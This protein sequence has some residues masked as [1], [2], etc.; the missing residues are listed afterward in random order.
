MNEQQRRRVDDIKG[1]L[2]LV[3]FPPPFI[4]DN[5]AVCLLA[6]LD[7]KPGRGDLL[8]GKQTLHDGAR[9]R[10]I[11]DFSRLDLNRPVAENTREEYRKR[12]LKPLVVTGMVAVHASSVNDPNTYYVLNPD[13]EAI[14]R[15]SDSPR[16]RA[17]IEAWNR[18][19]G[20]ILEK[21]KERQRIGQVLVRIDDR[22]IQLS[23]GE[24]NELIV[25]VLE[26]FA[27]ALA[28]G[29][30][31][32]Y[33][34]DQRKKMLYVNTDL[35]ARLNIVL[36]EHDKL[37]DVM[38]YRPSSNTLFVVEAV[39]S[40]GPMSD[41]RKGEIVGI[42]T[43]RGPIQYGLVMGTAFPDRTMFRKF[44]QEIGWDTFV[45]IS[46]EGFGVIYF[47]RIERGRRQ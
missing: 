4:T 15:E 44:V 24:H 20:A 39:T 19:H 17:L 8:P 29:A 40:V 42:L 28:P 38:F 12:S 45:W 26:Q 18:N 34:G 46:S 33:V 13:F 10:N 30:I 31:I 9:I 47:D 6:L 37:P 23:A 43:K 35:L 5:T 27:P 2:G 25:A 14:L 41:A 3:G 1:V 11:L 7:R 22:E 32:A 36:D 21:I 16:R